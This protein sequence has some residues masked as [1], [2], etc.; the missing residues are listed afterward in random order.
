MNGSALELSQTDESS[1]DLQKSRDFP[2]RVK[3]L[4][5]WF[6]N[7]LVLLEMLKL[8][9]VLRATVLRHVLL[10]RTLVLR[11]MIN[12]PLQQVCNILC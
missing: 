5:K 11:M 1:A 12:K 7:E 4:E 6:R 2:D 3:I 10:H 8:Y 9:L